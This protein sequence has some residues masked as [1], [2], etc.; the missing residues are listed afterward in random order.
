MEESINDQETM[1]SYMSDVGNDVWSMSVTNKYITTNRVY[2]WV[3]VFLGTFKLYFFL[4]LF[5]Q[6]LNTK[7]QE[8]IKNHSINCVL[9]FSS[10]IFNQ[11]SLISWM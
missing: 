3:S 1:S 4:L 5:S 7:N 2:A 10:L 9:A 11:A 8:R 6:Y